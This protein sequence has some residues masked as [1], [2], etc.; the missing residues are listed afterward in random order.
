MPRS[1][2]YREAT[3]D[4]CLEVI[5]LVNNYEPVVDEIGDIPTSTVLRRIAP[6]RSQEWLLRFT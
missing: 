6:K 3:L 1:E 2:E 5:A 4:E